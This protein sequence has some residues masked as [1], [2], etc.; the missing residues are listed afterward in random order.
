MSTA[1]KWIFL[2]MAC[3]IVASTAVWLSLN[4]TA[5][6]DGH[7][8]V[9]REQPAS[10]LAQQTCTDD[11]SIEIQ[12]LFDRLDFTFKDPPDYSEEDDLGIYFVITNSSCQAVDLKVEFRGSVSDAVIH[13]TDLTDSV[14][15]LNGC[16]IDAEQEFYGN[17]GWDLGRH[18]NTEKEYVVGTITITGPGGFVDQTS[19]NNTHTSTEWINIVNEVSATATPTPTPTATP[20]ATPTVT[21]TPTAT[22]TATPTPTAT[23]TPTRRPQLLLLRPPRRQLLLPL[24]PRPLPQHR[25]Q[26]PLLRP[27]RRQLRLPLHGDRNTVTPTP[28][29]TA[30]PTAHHDGNS[31][32]HSNRD[33][34]PNTNS[35]SNSDTDGH[36]HSD[37]DPNRYSNAHRD[38]NRYP[39]SYGD[40]YPNTNSHS[41]SNTDSHEHSDSNRHSH[42]NSNSTAAVGP[43][44]CRPQLYR[45]DYR[46]AA[47]Y[48]GRH[49]QFR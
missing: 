42:P 21:P 11:V 24:Q 47:H 16:T 26:L 5:P 20:T 41:N 7:G 17:V 48:C 39:H 22:A 37:T 4:T 31:D 46:R 29:A 45:G 27:P 25:P 8:A 30:T 34:Y 15:C 9:V 19:S 12:G 35:H 49:Q 13:N 6:V 44:S 32:S 1:L 38:G 43:A 3:A 23:V 28:T 18:P 40:R 10:E 33:R 2:A 36:E 14:A